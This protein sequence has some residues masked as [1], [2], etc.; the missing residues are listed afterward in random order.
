MRPLL[1]QIDL[2]ALRHNYQLAKRAHGGQVLAVV[3]ANAYGHG[4]VECAR[5]LSCADGFAVAAI[6]EAVRLRLA[7]IT[8][9]ILLM[10]G[11]F[12]AAEWDSVMQYD[13][14]CVIQSN[15]QLQSFLAARLP[16]P[17]TIWLKMD[18]GMHR[19]G[20]NAPDYAQAYATL[21]Q[22]DKV[23]HIVAMSHYAAADNLAS[24]LTLAQTQLFDG[25]LSLCGH[26]EAIE[27]SL[28]NSAAILAHPSS[29]RQWGRA[30]L[31][32]YGVSPFSVDD[33]FAA[34]L[35]PVMTL[36]TQI[37][38]VRTLAAGETIG[39]GATYTTQC[40]TRV[41]LVACGYADGYP[42]AASNMANVLVCGQPCPI[43][44]R[45][46]MDMM[47]IDI[48]NVPEADVGSLVT[49]WGEGVSVATVAEQAATIA[50]ELL[51][52][53]KRAHFLYQE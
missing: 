48:T 4:A 15:V 22:H 17:V 20:F 29:Y 26:G 51:C 9:P 21:A 39:Y 1:A 25:V 30:G 34:D 13:L 7:N 44:G 35:K 19:A 43:L 5:A 31:M 23:G 37:F 28:A 3:K 36:S 40:T 53:V 41:G 16:N 18:S 24:P 46:S 6:E 50:Y 49:L 32:L 10:E 42:R 14:W 27:V 38:G 52:N 12:E 33:G 2:S 11:V 45:I 47:C 8:Q